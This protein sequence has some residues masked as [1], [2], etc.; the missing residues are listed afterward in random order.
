MAAPSVATADSSSAD[1]ETTPVGRT[2]EGVV[3]PSFNFPSQPMSVPPSQPTIPGI[4]FGRRTFTPPPDWAGPE[5]SAA[6]HGQ[7]YLER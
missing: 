2:I 3:F 4:R 5:A 7:G 1:G 6:A